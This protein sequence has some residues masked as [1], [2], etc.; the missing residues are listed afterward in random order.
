MKKKFLA[1]VMTLAMVLSLVPVTALA[2]DGN[3]A[4][5][6]SASQPADDGTNG[7]G[8]SASGDSGA[9]TGGGDN[10]SGG[11]G[12]TEGGTSTGDS[13]TPDTGTG[14]EGDDT[15]TGSGTSSGGSSEG[16][17]TEPT[18]ET[19]ENAAKIG[20]TEYESLAKAINN[21]MSGDT[22]EL[23]CDV[24]EDITI[25]KSLTLDL[26]GFTL[27]GT[28]SGAVVTISGADTNVTITGSAIEGA[29]VVKGKITGGNNAKTAGG[30]VAVLNATVEIENLVITN[31]SAN[32][33]GGI[34]VDN[35]K[36]SL[37]GVIVTYNEA[38]SCGGG[39]ELTK[40]TVNATD[41]DITHN[42][43]KRGGGVDIG[44]YY[45]IPSD[46]S[47]SSANFKMQGETSIS[48]NCATGTSTS[49]G[50]GGGIFLTDMSMSTYDTATKKITTVI[51]LQTSFTMDG[52]TISGNT[53]EWA[54]GAIMCL[55][56][57]G[58]TLQK[59]SIV[60]NSAKYYGGGVCIQKF[61]ND[62]AGNCDYDVL[63]IKAEVDLNTNRAAYG[64]GVAALKGVDVQLEA[65]A[66]LYNNI[67]TTMGDDVYTQNGV[68]NLVAANKMGGDLTL[69]TTKTKI[70]GWYHDGYNAKTL[71]YS[72]WSQK[73]K[74]KTV[75]E[76]GVTKDA[77]KE[78]YVE[79]IPQKTI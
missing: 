24:T 50:G 43:A 12:G 9:T 29:T 61:M 74:Q 10:E 55:N 39:I 38:M 34:Y 7:S 57:G 59:G 16:G 73:G 32:A 58:I 30:G 67:A 14:T 71:D 54:G 76:T 60:Q 36:V 18:P 53:T 78:N 13:S 27:T 23:L 31:N 45:V 56:N 46:K 21:A 22:V 1:L 49:N 37:N 42:T 44:S 52:G 25:S 51:V 28:G 66:S 6:Q 62:T 65:G 79:Y 41:S 72:R 70:T 11:T 2:T 69:D 4:G 19:S 33:G 17:E 47:V 3:D 8:S 63:N 35:G 20:E 15:G 48:N 5:E 75:S 77:E 26:C 64:G 68:L 40:G